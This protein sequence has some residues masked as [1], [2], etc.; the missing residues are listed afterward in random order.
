MLAWGLLMTLLDMPYI[1]Q[2]RLFVSYSRSTRTVTYRRTTYSQSNSQLMWIF[3]GFF[4][5][6]VILVL[7]CFFCYIKC[8]RKTPA[9]ETNG[10]SV[11]GTAGPRYDINPPQYSQTVEPGHLSLKPP[12]GHLPPRYSDIINTSV[13]V[14]PSQ[15]AD[16]PAFTTDDETLTD[17]NEDIR[18]DSCGDIAVRERSSEVQEG[19]TG[20]PTNETTDKQEKDTPTHDKAGLIDNEVENSDD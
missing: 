11:I 13:D 4:F 9:P 20:E 15:G 19:M 12:D 16:N 17:Q 1:V 10:A 8:R 2:S 14:T 3:V 18:I 7:L 5:G 6:A